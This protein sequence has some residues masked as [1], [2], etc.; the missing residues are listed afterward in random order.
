MIPSNS[1]FLMVDLEEV[2]QPSLTYKLNIDA[3]TVVGKCDDLEA[4]KQAIYK[5]LNT[6]RYRYLIYSWNYG[7]E[8]EELFGEPISYCIPEIE[9]RITEALMQDDRVI[10]VYNFEFDHHGREV[11][12]K[13]I[14]ETVFGTVDMEKDVAI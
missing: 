4:M 7:V 2:N 10:N 13:F 6:E 12:T 3:E 1:Q 14:V 9:R 8:L 5:V 11:S